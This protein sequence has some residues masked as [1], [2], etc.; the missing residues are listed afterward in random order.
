LL[1]GVG[2]LMLRVVNSRAGFVPAVVTPPRT[3]ADLLGEPN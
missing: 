1:V 2:G 3:P